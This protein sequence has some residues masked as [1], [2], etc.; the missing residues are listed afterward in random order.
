MIKKTISLRIAE[1]VLD[2]F[3][4]TGINRSKF[5]EDCMRA[6]VETDDNSLGHR[7]RAIDEDIRQLQYQ[8]YI[9]TSR[10]SQ[11]YEKAQEI[12]EKI[13]AY[14]KE[15]SEKAGDLFFGL[16]DVEDFDDLRMISGLLK[17]DLL[18]LS[19]YLI[20]NEDSP[21]YK[22]LCADFQYCLR[23]YNKDKGRNLG[24]DL[25]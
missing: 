22:L 3:T 8:K 6:Y 17:R 2:A 1:D 7:I 18:D 5:C 10:Y 19:E 24:G 23:Q 13:P 12:N 14:W 21:D 9:L 16:C 25:L 11:D 20:D 15:F 4:K